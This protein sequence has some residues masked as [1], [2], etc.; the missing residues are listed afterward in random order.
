MPAATRGTGSQ[1]LY[2][3]SRRKFP[4]N[5]SSHADFSTFPTLNACE[6]TVLGHKIKDDAVIRSALAS[7]PDAKVLVDD[8]KDRRKFSYEPQRRK[9]LVREPRA[10]ARTVRAGA[11]R[12]TVGRPLTGE[13]LAKDSRDSGS[14]RNSTRKDHFDYTDQAAVNP[15]VRTMVG[16]DDDRSDIR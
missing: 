14:S 1:P 8:Y 4:Q 12:V 10:G 9:W 6:G 3:R 2:S 11:E 15:G 13:T 5:G 7:H 16:P